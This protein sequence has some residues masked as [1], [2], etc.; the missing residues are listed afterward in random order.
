ML[1]QDEARRL[2]E[3]DPRVLSTEQQCAYVLKCIEAGMSP[4]Q[5]LE[6]RFRGDRFSFDLVMSFAVERGWVARDRKSGNWRVTK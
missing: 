1:T 4:M 6:A 5:I 3:M 2:E